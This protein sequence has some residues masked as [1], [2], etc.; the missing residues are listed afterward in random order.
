MLDPNCKYRKGEFVE[1]PKKELG[2]GTG[3]VIEDHRGDVVKVF[4]E[5][6]PNIKT[7]KPSYVVLNKISDPG[8]A[9]HFLENALV[10]EESIRKGDRVPFP[11][12]LAKFLEDFPG[13]F[14]GKLLNEY[15]RKY[16]LEAH[17]WLMK[18]LSKAQWAQYLARNDFDTL[19]QEIKRLYGKT[20]LLSSFEMIKL[21]DALKVDRAK[22]D[23]CLALFDLLY[24]EG[25]IKN[26]FEN[27]ATILGR[28][29]IDKW[30]TLTY[31]LFMSNPNKYMFVKP[32]MTQE[33]ASNRGFDI[34]YSPDVNWNT[35]KHILVFS[36]DL[37]SR[38]AESE[39]EDLHPKDM[40]DVQSFMWCA[41]T[42]SWTREDITNAKAKLELT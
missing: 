5:N 15:E 35:Y 27:T 25:I 20:N 12:L 3:V 14:K 30:T 21:N 17:E 34:H 39:N 4:F 26:R 23:I 18:H 6:E 36:E 7:L 38:L 42:N 29:E 37:F 9:R 33:A 40:I 10:E 24:G 2:W 28:Y 11:K 13:G 41:F 1:H 19:A 32:T 8:K 16:K 31:P 22:E